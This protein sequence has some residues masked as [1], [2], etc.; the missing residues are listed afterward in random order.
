MNTSRVVLDAGLA[1]CRVLD[2]RSHP[3]VVRAWEQ[4]ARDEMAL[5]APRLWRY[6]VTSVIHKHVYAGTLTPEEGE[7]ALQTAWDFGVDL[8]SEDDALCLAALR[9]ATRLRQRAAYDAFYLA[10]AERVGAE[11]W[12]TDGRLYRNARDL[13]VSWVRAVGEF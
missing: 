12:T 3:L 1:V 5:Y 7:Q 6:E 13:G 4:F 8:I 11:F 2:P 9:W 10:L